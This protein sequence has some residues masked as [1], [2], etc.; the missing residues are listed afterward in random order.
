MELTAG[1]IVTLSAAQLATGGVTL[2]NAGEAI[3]MYQGAIDAPAR[4]LFA[5][6]VADGN[7]TFNGS[8]VNTGLTVGVNAVAVQ[9]D[10]ASYA[11]SATQIPQ[12]QLADISN[13]T[14]WHGSDTDDNGGT[15]NYTEVADTTVSNTFTNP[16]MVIIAGMAG[17]GQS[18]AILRI[19]NDEGANVG[20]HLARLF[21]DNPAFNHITD[22][23]FD[24]EGGFFFFADSDGNS[25]NRIMRGNIADLVSGIS[26]PSFTQ[27]FA[28]DGQNNG[29]GPV[30]LGELINGLEIDKT[31]NKVYWWDGNLAGDFEGGWQ[32][33]SI[34][35][36]GTGLT[37]ITT[38]DTEN[39]A[40]DPLG[41]PGGMGDWALDIPHGFAY[42]VSS[43]GQVD[44]LGN[45]TLV[46]NHI[47]R[48]NLAT[49]VITILALGAADVRTDRGPGNIYNDGRL[50][51]NE[52][53]IIALDV[54]QTT[55]VVYF[56]TQPIGP[57]NT[58][59][60]WSYNPATDTLVELWEQ[61]SNNAF[62][63]LQSFPTA[64]MTHIEVDEIGGRIYISATSDTDSEF[65]GTPAT[66]EDDAA[67]FSLAI[68]AAVG[69]P[70]TLFQ[71]V[72]E[73]TAN[74]A[75]QGME[76]DYA[77]VTGVTTA[78]ATYT[79]STNGTNSPAGPVVTPFTNA[80]V[81]DAD[82]TV[83]Q[84]AT[85]AISS[86]FVVGDTL[87]FTNSGGITGSYN[88]ATG[89]VT[90]T[91]SATAAQY[92]TV[93]NS[94]RFT[95]AGDNPTNYGYN[96]TRTISVT[97]FDGLLNSDP[98]SVTVTIVGINDAPVN[99]VGGTA[100]A[101]EDTANPIS[102]I[103]VFDVD[104]DP[105]AQDVTV[106]LTVTNGTLTVLTNVAGGIQASD[107]IGNNTATIVITATQNQINATLAAAS[108]LSYTPTLNYNGAATLTVTTNDIGRNGN[109]PG[110][111]GTGTSEQDQDVKAITIADVNDAPTVAGD[112]TED[113]T[114]IL[115]DTPMQQATP[116]VAPTVAAIFGGQF[117]D[118]ADIQVTGGNPTGSVGDTF[119]GIAIVADGS[120][121]GDRAVGILERRR[122]DRYRRGLAGGGAD[123]HGRDPDPFQ[124]GAQ[125]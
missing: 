120:N 30:M 114:T 59:G 23:T 35:Y 14:R 15:P 42:T 70:P 73:V 92:Q 113:M 44:G 106:T 28:T 86:N 19:G 72:V 77:P 58:S 68:G 84:G 45:V 16:D 17:G 107:V 24:I 62:N 97:T 48:V 13:N 125:L 8:L 63:T 99:T 12:T 36:D 111:T 41:F 96:Q 75:P 20:S 32:L 124:P 91:G 18:D 4:F 116:I 67:I 26:N 105:A 54:H 76:I 85:V 11:G 101:T 3:Y 2:S 57:G 34:N 51:P 112:G 117:A 46:Q 123:L 7:S 60:I 88:A 98:A 102:G 115:E 122:L 39:A 64:N 81:S 109:D 47:A 40:G 89:V 104:A 119:A 69:T 9:F 103:S 10:N 66:N 94:I 1:S 38:M 33:N 90:F 71:R 61:P 74:G 6:E 82:T 31:N 93:L 87:S 108:G 37:V 29:T 65:D 118:A 95:N 56:I 80:T 110:L 121:S 5:I 79:E 27:I 50:N 22:M 55:G 52:G 78:N 83:I 25:I 53:Q 100:A 49:G 21:R 43:R